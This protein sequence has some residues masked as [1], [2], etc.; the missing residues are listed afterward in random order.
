VLEVH[1]LP[2]PRFD[3]GGF[4]QVEVFQGV[5]RERRVEA[6]DALDRR[7]LVEQRLLLED[8]GDLAGQPAGA[9]RLVDD[10]RAA[11]L[12]EGVDDRLAVERR[13]RAQVDDLDVDLAVESPWRRTASRAPP[14]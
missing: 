6:G 4:G 14:P 3:A 5:Q 9:G 7:L 2:D 11:G 12:L 8:R 1:G 10:D 13:Q